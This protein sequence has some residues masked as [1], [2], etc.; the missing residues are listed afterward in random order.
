MRDSLFEAFGKSNYKLLFVVF[1][2]DS[3]NPAV[4]QPMKTFFSLFKDFDQLNYISLC[5]SFFKVFHN[6]TI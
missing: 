1:V 3:L 5:C 6:Q 4:S 2:F